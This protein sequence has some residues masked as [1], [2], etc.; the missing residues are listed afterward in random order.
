MVLWSK[1]ADYYMAEKLRL[2]DPRPILDTVPREPLTSTGDV[3]KVMQQ[4][5][6]A[7]RRAGLEHLIPFSV[8]Y[9]GV[10]VRGHRKLEDGKSPEEGG[11]ARPDVVAKAI[12][13]FGQKWFNHLLYFADDNREEIPNIWLYG[14]ESP[15]MLHAPPASQFAIPMGG[16]ID[17]D[18]PGTLDGIDAPEDY[19]PDYSNHFGEILAATAEDHSKGL[20]PVQDFARYALTSGVLRL[21]AMK[22]EVAW[23]KGLWLMENRDEVGERERFHQ[24]LDRYSMLS[25]KLMLHAGGF[26]LKTIE[27]LF[28]AATE[29]HDDWS[30][31]A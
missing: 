26:A 15:N 12:P 20:L 8:V 6:D 13:S 9:L 1:I 30:I 5:P 3:V 27:H 16:H 4:H 18:L 2:K 14:F 10:T 28:P 7:L 31:A 21:I 23:R 25:G 22:R 17:Y 24:Q 19:H 11:F 29:A